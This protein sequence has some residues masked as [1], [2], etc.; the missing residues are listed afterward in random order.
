MSE[1]Y[2]VRDTKLGREVAV[3]GG[4][5]ALEIP[6]QQKEFT[7]FMSVFYKRRAINRRRGFA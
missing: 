4:N 1:V 2:K 5:V 6:E 3:V 7:G